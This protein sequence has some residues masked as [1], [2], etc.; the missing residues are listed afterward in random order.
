MSGASRPAPSA[1]A[2]PRAT[3]RLVRARRGAV[4][5]LVAVLLVGLVGCVALGIDIGRLYLVGTE[6]QTAADA[7][8]LAAARALQ[9]SFNASS[10]GAEGEADE[11]ARRN[12]ANGAAVSIASNDVRP[13]LYDPATGGVTAS[14]WAAANAVE[15]TA[16][17]TGTYVFGKALGAIAP[18]VARKSVAWIANVTRANCLKPVALPYSALYQQ[19][20]GG[21][22]TSPDVTQDHIALI[23][24]MSPSYK[25]VIMLPPGTTSGLHDNGNWTP[26]TFTNPGAAAFEYTGWMNGSACN[27][28]TARVDEASVRR[29]NLTG[30][31]LITATHASV[32]SICNFKSA[33]DARCFTSAAAIRHGLPIRV[34]FGDLANASPNSPFS[35][36][37]IGNVI[38]M[39]YY[40]ASTDV[41]ANDPSYPN[42]G[43][44]QAS[45]T[46]YPPGTFV[47][48]VEAPSTLT[49]TPDVE[50]GDQIGPTQRLLLVQ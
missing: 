29:M 10:G 41:C 1:R 42:G 34:I 46:G 12:R 50:Y 35:T 17:R 38:L 2:T 9:L 45:N 33:S 27:T 47:I 28:A 37:A 14:T 49:R 23:K 8:A 15:V 44:Y 7:G 48:M 6:L 40:R 5:P 43:W 30:T 39:C 32:A 21:T 25:S 13:M 11:A 18:S 16:R 31:D 19:A 24:Q 4:L 22:G 20:W 3:R 26:V 36:R